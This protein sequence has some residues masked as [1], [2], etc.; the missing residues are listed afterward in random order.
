MSKYNKSLS[1]IDSQH[2]TPPISDSME[3]D[4]DILVTDISISHIV[5]Y[6]ADG[7]YHVMC[8]IDNMPENYIS[9]FNSNMG[10]LSRHEQDTFSHGTAISIVTID[11]AVRGFVYAKYKTG[12]FFKNIVSLSF[13]SEF[14]DGPNVNQ[15]P[16]SELQI[17]GKLYILKQ[18]VPN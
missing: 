9:D 13:H 1:V 3:N 4:G 6:V 15:A 14:V 16:L 5:Y 7:E 10:S 12:A 8:V 11:S 18:V 2:I 17:S